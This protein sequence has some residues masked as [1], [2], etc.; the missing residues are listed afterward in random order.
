L[1]G[2]KFAKLFNILNRDG[3]WNTGC[4]CPRA[5]GKNPAA[6]SSPLTILKRLSVRTRVFEVVRRAGIESSSM[7]FSSVAANRGHA[8]SAVDYRSLLGG[9]RE[10]E[11]ERQPYSH[12]SA[13]THHNLTSASGPRNSATPWNYSLCLRGIPDEWLRE[14]K[15]SNCAGCDECL[16]DCASIGSLLPGGEETRLELCKIE[17]QLTGLLQLRDEDRHDV[18]GI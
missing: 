5:Y 17:H 18:L 7:R 15:P 3:S 4:G 16:A 10:R 8:D 6:E 11:R 9:E 2:Q 13:E 12:S 1:S 14:V